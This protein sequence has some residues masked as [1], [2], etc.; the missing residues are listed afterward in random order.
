LHGHWIITDSNDRK[1]CDWLFAEGRR[2]GKSLWWY[3]NGNKMR[4][5]NYADG[6]VHGELLEW[7]EGGRLV[8][9]VQ[10]EEGR[11]LDQTIRNYKSGQKQLEGMVLHARLIMKQPDDWWKAKLAT[12]VQEGKDQKHGAWSAWYEDGKKKFQ[13]SYEYDQPTGD[14]VWWHLNGQK[15]LEGAYQDGKKSGTWTWW[16]PNGQKSIEGRFQNDAASDQWIWWHESGKVAQRV[17]FSATGGQIVTLPE[18]RLDLDAEAM[19]RS[20]M[21]H[22]PRNW[23]ESLGGGE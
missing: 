19:G 17:D 8:T 10:Y 16:H 22:Q 23:G 9:R 21:L 2:D 6:Q 14:F 18:G 7:D 13:G 1:I 5:I 15:A 20:I 11:R 3:Q 12:Y 4:E